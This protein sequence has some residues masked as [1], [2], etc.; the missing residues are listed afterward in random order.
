MSNIKKIILEEGAESF[1]TSKNILETLPH[2]PVERGYNEKRQGDLELPPDMG[3]EI[4]H[5]IKY[6][7]DFLKPCPGTKDYICCGYQIL[8][9]GTNC[10]LD[11]SYCILQS[12]VNRPHLRVFVNL[13]EELEKLI[14]F[15]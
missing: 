5:L 8:N 3:K 1:S 9:I 4:L 11:C 6:K 2:I 7:G 12:Y 10:P 15:M 13:E 14:E